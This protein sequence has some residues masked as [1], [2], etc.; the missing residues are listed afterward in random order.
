MTSRSLVLVLALASFTGIL[1]QFALVPLLPEVADDIDSTVPLL[2]QT[3]TLTFLAGAL[4]ALAIGPL[5]DHYGHR[6]LML[7]GASLLVLSAIGTA[8]AIDYWTIL[9][10]RL[11]GGLGGGILTSVSV[12]LASTR[13]PVEQRRW[14]I[15]WT[16]SGLSAAPIIGVP[17]ITFVGEHLGWRVSF[18]ILGTLALVSGLLVHRLVS[19]DVLSPAERFH[20][21]DTLEAYRPILTNGPARRQQISNLLRAIGWGAALTYLSA[22][23]FDVHGLSLQGISYLFF[24]IG[25]GYFLGTRLGDGRYERISLHTAFAVSTMMMGM[26]FAVM[27]LIHASL[28]IIIVP[29]MIAVAAGGIGFVS[30]T[31]IM[32]EESPAGPATTMML[33]Q[34]GFSLGL[35]GGG[36]VGGLSLAL[37]GYGLLGFGVVIFAIA[38]AL[39]VYRTLKVQLPVEEEL[40]SDADPLAAPPAVP[41]ARTER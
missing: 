29:L 1:A 13:F 19:A 36:A 14:A 22:Y 2:G 15:G 28:W 8:L 25:C 24:V 18:L 40:P 38:S 34:S 16:V 39:A 27:F 23:M 33:R 37:G 12:V 9:L 10:T 32:S 21:I 41:M 5:A 7:I 4:L 20:M 6:R 26:M 3:I 17:L 30:L 35:A 11:P 31:I